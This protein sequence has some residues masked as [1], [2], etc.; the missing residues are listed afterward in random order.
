MS[1]IDR[2][3][4]QELPPLEI[5]MVPDRA[6]RQNVAEV[7][8]ESP[9]LRTMAE[10]V[11]GDERMFE[12]VADFMA[13]RAEFRADYDRPG[14]NV[15]PWFAAIARENPDLLDTALDQ[16]FIDESKSFEN[17]LIRDTSY[18]GFHYAPKLVVGSGP[19]SQI[20]VSALLD[21]QPDSAKDISVID[22]ATS[23]GGTFRSD[24]AMNFRLNSRTRRQTNEPPVPGT[25]SNLNTLVPGVV[26]VPDIV[27]ETYAPADA[28][29]RAIRI[30]HALNNSN[31]GL[32][33]E[34]VSITPDPIQE[35]GSG[36]PGNVTVVVRNKDSETYTIRTDVLVA[37]TGN[38]EQRLD[39]FDDETKELVKQSHEAFKN[40][41][42]TPVVIYGDLYE[43][44][45]R[46]RF[47]L[48]GVKKVAII[49]DGDSA[50]T[51]V[52]TLLGYE[53]R[54]DGSVIQIDT[55]EEIT[56]FGQKAET[57]RD[58][59]TN[60]RFRYAQVALEFE[61]DTNSGRA[62]RI[63]PRN[64][65]VNTIAINEEDGKPRVA[66]DT[67]AFD[68]V[69]VATGNT[70]DG[71]KWLLDKV[72]Q[73]MRVDDPKV[74]AA[75]KNSP[76][77]RYNKLEAG[78][79]IIFPTGYNVRELQILRSYNGPMSVNYRVAITTSD[80]AVSVGYLDRV[81]GR[82][83]SDYCKL[84]NFSSVVTT[85]T[86]AEIEATSEIQTNN[87]VEV[88]QVAD[89]GLLSAEE[90]LAFLAK[91]PLFFPGAYASDGNLEQ[92]LLYRVENGVPDFD[93]EIFITG[94]GGS[95]DFN[96]SYRG[97]INVDEWNNA[98]SECVNLG[99]FVV[100]PA[101]TNLIDPVLIEDE[102]E[103]ITPT[104]LSIDEVI[105]RL[106]ELTDKN[107]VIKITSDNPDVK[108]PVSIAALY[109]N[110]NGEIKYGYYGTVADLWESATI[111]GRGQ[112]VSS[113]GYTTKV[114]VY[115]PNQAETA[116]AELPKN[117][118]GEEFKRLSRQEQLK[119]LI[120]GQSVIYSGRATFAVDEVA[121]ATTGDFLR[122]T[123]VS[124]GDGQG[125]LQS[126]G[127]A[128]VEYRNS[129]INDFFSG[130][131]SL[132]RGVV[133]T[134]GL[135]QSTIDASKD[136]EVL[137]LDP[138]EIA[139]RLEEFIAKG[140]VF[141]DSRG[142]SF[143][144]PVIFQPNLN[145]DDDKTMLFYTN[146]DRVSSLDKSNVS[147]S[148]Y[149]SRN[150][151]NKVVIPKAQPASTT[152]TAQTKTLKPGT[153]FVSVPEPSVID[154]IGND[155]EP[156]A[157]QLKDAPVILAGPA[158]GLKVS[159][160]A[161]R[162]I[163]DIPENSAGIFISQPRVNELAQQLGNVST[164]SSRAKDSTDLFGELEYFGVVG[165]KQAEYYGPLT[166]YIDPAL[167]LNFRAAKRLSPDT[168]LRF[169]LGTFFRRERIGDDDS[170][171]TKKSAFKIATFDVTK[172][173]D[174]LVVTTEKKS[175]KS[176]VLLEP[177]GIEDLLT[178]PYV[179]HAFD[180]MLAG[181]NVSSV[182]VKLPFDA[183]GLVLDGVEVTK[184]K[185][186]SRRQVPTTR[187]E[188]AD[189]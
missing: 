164:R 75:I 95:P 57:D 62:N 97:Y 2:E 50:R 61:R 139:A 149:F 67:T 5:E 64:R 92:N 19:Q 1:T 134:P 166:T 48:K 126:T 105:Q 21:A 44:L 156:I 74:Q 31:F 122:L 88:M 36:L 90:K 28:L 119:T 93:N 78:D 181:K 42:N 137:R 151:W 175:S 98:V 109:R 69:V 161:T 81:T 111:F 138:E 54:P 18:N 141:V 29:G 120:P 172:D 144:T 46:E 115:I 150:S 155:G 89:Y 55:V 184:Q 84:E 160:D 24:E 100:N 56:W 49:G 94:Y 68:L 117:Y 85:E 186:L 110:E 16:H 163:P 41:A 143:I 82:D 135:L 20:F 167:A 11:R 58:F 23:V 179:Y 30:N 101:L 87:S 79:T 176:S 9:A 99:L 142:I 159:A 26:T 59:I 43:R 140:A 76:D 12:T 32:G 169:G 22:K 112:L 154:V 125:G 72:K 39:R 165:K 173:E 180:R 25:T 116:P 4:S 65:T 80:G 27:T 189:S 47:P 152:P 60:N 83:L 7:L 107:A 108:P 77:N 170:E 153:R 104:S 45:D 71:E 40:G 70:A 6:G 171:A 10:I 132:L 17:L 124:R 103:R 38:G 114:D 148:E 34:V 3:I 123:E 128:S 15:A 91:N 8:R 133:N 53:P 188:R 131:T 129:S 63:T 102:S 127:L 185:K 13:R 187:A 147:S 51:A 183:R 52:G 157:R 14:R 86:T 106:D 118:T 113:L 37:T 66:N 162:L 73:P 174:G 182:K 168:M 146:S 35:S 136:V 121:S 96:D 158:A 130:P 33:L 177:E 178:E 145:P